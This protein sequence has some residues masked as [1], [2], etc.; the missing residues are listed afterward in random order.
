MTTSSSTFIA[1]LGIILSNISKF[2]KCVYIFI[3]FK[4]NITAIAAVTA[5]RSTCSYKQFASE[6]Y[7][8]IP[9]TTRFNI[10]FCTICK[11]FSSSIFV[12]L[13]NAP[14]L[15]ITKIWGQLSVIIQQ[16]LQDIQKPASCLCLIS[17][18]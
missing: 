5:I 3:N 15:C 1:I 4:Y 8:A 7:M 6:T 13:K 2:I 14:N 10:Y 17:Q 12:S 16:Q 9:A 11:H 18:I